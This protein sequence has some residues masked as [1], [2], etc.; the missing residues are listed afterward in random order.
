[1]TSLVLLDVL[2]RSTPLILLGLAVSLAF[3]AGV[4]SIG[5]EGQFL[6]GA[7][8]AVAVALAFPSWPGVV[9]VPLELAAGVAAGAAWSGVAAVLKARFG[10]L[11]V[12]STLM[13]N[14]VAQYGVSYLVRG[15]LQEPT[16]VYPQTVT[17]AEHARL[18][19]LLP[20]GGVHAGISVAIAIAVALWW[21]I[22]STGAGFRVRLVGAGASAAASAGRVHVGR[23]LFGVFLGSGAIA[24]LSGAVEAT[25]VTYALYEGISPGF[26]YTAIAVA[27]LARLDPLA[28]IV[29]GVLFGALETGAAALQR[30]AGVPAVFVSVIEALVVLGVLAADRVR[31][32]ATARATARVATASTEAT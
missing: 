23:V 10:V 17:L 27:L 20:Y 29:T 5:A 25:D 30:N 6:A 8:A 7:S 12:I 3:R 31:D 32:V 19:A 28:V 26:G 14:F 9:L 16:R 13:L 2:V 1:V 15:P 22:G 4:L 18:P 11:E 24:G 21:T